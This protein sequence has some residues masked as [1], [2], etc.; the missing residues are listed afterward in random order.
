MLFS[1]SDSLGD[2]P[3]FLVPGTKEDKATMLNLLLNSWDPEALFSVLEVKDV[4]YIHNDMLE[5]K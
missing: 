1:L 4:A 2:L 5:D 3:Y